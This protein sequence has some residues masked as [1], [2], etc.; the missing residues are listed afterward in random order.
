M[1]FKMDKV[2]QIIEQLR[3]NKYYAGSDYMLDH[4]NENKYLLSCKD[5]HTTQILHILFESKE[6]AIQYPSIYRNTDIVDGNYKAIPFDYK[7]RKQMNE[8][9]LLHSYD[10]LMFDMSDYRE[11]SYQRLNKLMTLYS[12]ILIRANGHRSIFSNYLLREMILDSTYEMEMKLSGD[13]YPLCIHYKTVDDLEVYGILAPK[14]RDPTDDD[15]I[16]E[17]K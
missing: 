8:W 9:D 13:D 15:I 14:L 10:S 3:Y 12:N 4:V 5:I 6:E 1:V 7:N 2:K 11:C 16:F 17:V